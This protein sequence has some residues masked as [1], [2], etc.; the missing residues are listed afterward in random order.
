MREKRHVNLRPLS[1]LRSTARTLAGRLLDEAGNYL[2]QPPV[3]GFGRAHTHGP[4]NA[5][6]IALTYDDG[7]N[8]PSTLELLDALDDCGVKATFFWVGV[9]ARSHPEIVRRAFAAGHVIGNHSMYHS[10]L[11]GLKPF[12]SAHIDEC[13][14]LL[15]DLI[16]VAPRLYRAPWGWLSPFE[17]ARL[18][19][20]GYEIIGWDTYTFDWQIPSPDGLEIAA[21][22]ERDVRPGSIVL[23]HDGIAGV[24]IA[25]KPHTIRATVE[26][27]HRFRDWGFT[28]VTIPEMLG[29]PAY[30]PSAAPDHVV[31]HI[32]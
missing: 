24:E 4:R 22:V 28:F 16:G 19:S 26:T 20:R 32:K 2:F 30:G 3:G 12:E 29:I 13:A 18:L 23:F 15:T 10:R 8:T 7:P 9:N 6:Q 25:D 27:I 17:T 1:P 14:A 11:S 5:K 31:G 21:Q